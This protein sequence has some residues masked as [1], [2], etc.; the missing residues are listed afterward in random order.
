MMKGFISWSGGKDCMNALYRFLNEQDN[1]V[2]CLLNMTDENSDRSRSHGISNDMIRRQAEKMGIPLVQY[3]TSRE[4]Y[5]NNSKK[6]ITRL[7][8]DGVDAG[9]FGDIYLQ[10]H[11]KWIESVCSELKIKAFFP[12]WG[13]DPGYLVRNFIKDGFKAVVVAVEKNRMDVRFLGRTIDHVFLNDLHHVH[14]IDV[15]G[16]NG[17]YHTFVF[18]GP[19]FNEAVPFETGVVIEDGDCC[20]L[21][22]K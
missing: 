17:E 2:L 10:A 12:L 20:F 3:P 6:I 7:K 16:E 15:C 8:A 4:Q 13:E 5:K 22:L 21:Q 19:I 9:I 11:R 14:G 18:D 1:E